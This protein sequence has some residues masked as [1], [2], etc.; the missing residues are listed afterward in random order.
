MDN[1]PFTVHKI[2]HLSASSIN[3]WVTD[4]C[5]WCLKYL[6]KIDSDYGASAQR[7]HIIEWALERWLAKGDI[8]TAKELE[9][10]FIKHLIDKQIDV[11]AGKAVE[12]IKNLMPYYEMVKHK[13][14]DYPNLVNYQEKLE[15]QYGDL[16]IP[17]IGYIDFVFDDFILDLKTTS[18]MPSICPETVKRQMAVYSM[19]Y[20][21][22]PMVV[23]FVTPKKYQTFK[24]DE[25]Q[26]YRRQ[27]YDICMGL[28]RFLGTSD[29]P[30]QLTQSFHPNFDHWAWDDKMK[31]EAKKIWR[32]I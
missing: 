7:G 6:M 31:N 32:F 4:P 8:V 10:L 11:E 13:Y 5:R 23:D 29:S 26:L 18:K 2:D 17:I 15:V 22:R 16:P 25:L 12:E 3:L 1:N 14:N 28:M 30:L 27:V 24:L 21:D 20:T 19:V 9:D